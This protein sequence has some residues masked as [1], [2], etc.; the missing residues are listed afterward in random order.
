[1]T[2]ISVLIPTYQEERY[3]SR[4]LDSILRN[5][6]DFP[7]T[8]S[9]I[10]VIDGM[11]TDRTRE[12]VRGFVE[13]HPFIRLVDNPETIQVK[14]LNIGIR[15]AKGEII[16]RC[17]AHCEYPVNYISEILKCH[18]ETDAA[19]I[20]CACVVMPGANTP[21]SRAISMAMNTKL[22]VGP[23][24]MFRGS[25]AIMP[26][27][28]DTVSF[29]AWKREV[30]KQ[31]GDFDEEFVR[32]QDFE[33]NTRLRKHG[34]KILLLPWVQVHYFARE[35]YG[36]LWGMCYQYGYWKVKVNKKHGALTSKR[37][38]IPPAV[39][40]ADFLVL[41]AA[42]FWNLALYAFLLGNGVYL[43]AVLASA[44]NAALRER[45]L[46]L[47]LPMIVAFVILH[48]G[49]GVGYIRG[50]IEIYVIRRCKTGDSLTRV[51]R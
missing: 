38:L 31:V 45:D 50:V 3:V 15:L 41:L 2:R 43:G 4:C 25:D 6:F 42:P 48:F 28:V 24:P 18:G 46:R 34:R 39:T 5:H 20:G 16:L 26:S 19:N 44:A 36:K 33:F 12:I 14:A 8:A 51:T 17:D 27:E 29:G 40:A 32:A 7:K 37:Q 11:S 10:L 23:T 13:R 1:M 47:V 22:G 49:Y 21:K 30:F 9:E 35:A